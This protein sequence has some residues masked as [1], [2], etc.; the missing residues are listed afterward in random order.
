MSFGFLKPTKAK[1]KSYIQAKRTMASKCYLLV[2]VHGGHCDHAAL[3]D[4]LMGFAQGVGLD[5][6]QVVA[7]KNHLLEGAMDVD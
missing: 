3:V 1:D 7:K 2:N 6:A 5:K 4:Q